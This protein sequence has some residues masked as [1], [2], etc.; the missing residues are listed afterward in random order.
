MIVKL[1]KGCIAGSSVCLIQLG[2]T[3]LGSRG[4]LH[5]A[6]VLRAQPLCRVDTRLSIVV[7][8][9]PPLLQTLSADVVDDDVEVVFRVLIY[10][11]LLLDLSIELLGRFLPSCYC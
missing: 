1:R 9:L 10:T 8:I 7:L 3:R 11:D 5:T 2:E 6:L 4:S